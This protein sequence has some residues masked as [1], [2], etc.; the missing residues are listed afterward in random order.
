MANLCNSIACCKTKAKAKLH[1]AIRG[2]GTLLAN[3]RQAG[4]EASARTRLVGDCTGLPR[5]SLRSSPRVLIRAQVQLSLAK[6]V[7][8]LNV[9]VDVAEG[10]AT[11]NKGAFIRRETLARVTWYLSHG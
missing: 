5:C 10:W 1:C 4:V 11:T 6:L 3:E 2:I 9:V 8:Q 7:G